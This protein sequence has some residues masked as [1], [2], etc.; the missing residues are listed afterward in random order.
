MVAGIIGVGVGVGVG[1]GDGVGV[2]LTA[3]PLFQT[4]FFPDLMQVKVL[5][6]TTDLVPALVHLAPAL[7]AETE[8]LLCINNAKIVVRRQS[9]TVLLNFFLLKFI[10]IIGPI[11]AILKKPGPMNKRFVSQFQ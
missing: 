11:L 7:V 3:T 1:V 5:F 6:P 10:G 9:A 2:G 8:G 4:N